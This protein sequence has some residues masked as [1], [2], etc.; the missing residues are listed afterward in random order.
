MADACPAAASRPHFF[1]ACFD[2][3]LPFCN[4]FR[5]LGNLVAGFLAIR[6]SFFAITR[7]PF[8]QGSL[9]DFPLYGEAQA[10]ALEAASGTII[11]RIDN[12]AKAVWFRTTVGFPGP[13]TRC[14]PTSKAAGSTRADSRPSP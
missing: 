12:T 10:R 14:R 9:C 4:F 5:R 1:L 8:D 7:S 2:W 3:I 6:L 13:L 11:G